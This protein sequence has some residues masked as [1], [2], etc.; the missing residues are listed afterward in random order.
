M[1]AEMAEYMKKVLLL[2]ILAFSASPGR[3][4]LNVSLT[5]Q[6]AIYAGVPGIART[7]EPFCQGVPLADSQGISSTS[8]LGLSGA[9]AGQFRILGVWPS[10]NAKWVGVCGLIPHLTAG[11]QATLPLTDARPANFDRTNRP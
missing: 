8:V 11:G 10:G 9:S 3:A 4:A 6:E 5:V 1:I 7:N 2:T